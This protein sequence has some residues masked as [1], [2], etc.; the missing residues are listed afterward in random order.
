[1]NSVVLIKLVPDLV[2]ELTINDSGTAI[3]QLISPCNAPSISIMP[4][5]TGVLAPMAR[6]TPISWVRSTT[7]MERE[8]IK[9]IPPTTTMM[10]AGTNSM[11]RYSAKKLS[12]NCR[13]SCMVSLSLISQ[14]RCSNSAFNWL[15]T[16]ST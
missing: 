8:P 2:E 1:M 15:V 5:I 4:I 6:I 13:F 12:K 9:P 3:I 14:L 11:P 7:L 16:A 10:M